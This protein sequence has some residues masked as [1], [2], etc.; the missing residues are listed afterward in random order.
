MLNP[1]E[2]LDCPVLEK[3]SHGDCNRGRCGFLGSLATTSGNLNPH[4]LET[5][6]W[7]ATTAV[8]GIFLHSTGV[9][10]AGKR[11]AS[12]EKAKPK[13]QVIQLDG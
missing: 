1:T 10:A 4:N 11:T 8:L 2:A 5:A 13:S 12:A 9:T 6:G 7:A 3:P